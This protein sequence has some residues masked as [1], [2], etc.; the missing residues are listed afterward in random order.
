VSFPAFGDPVR[1][2]RRIGV[3][4]KG[5][6]LIAAGD[7]RG[8]IVAARTAAFAREPPGIPRWG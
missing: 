2:V 6:D 8:F 5:K 4:E 1:R 7:H 3:R